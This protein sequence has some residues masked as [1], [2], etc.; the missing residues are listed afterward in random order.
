M[1]K[2]SFTIS[3]KN[4]IYRSSERLWLCLR[5]ILKFQNRR[6]DREESLFEMEA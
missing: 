2:T 4:W 1:S 6:Y 3:F 5:L